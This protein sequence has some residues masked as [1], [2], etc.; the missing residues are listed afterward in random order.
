MASLQH[1]IE[2]AVSAEQ[3]W[4]ALRE[5]GQTAR[6]F[7]P[8]LVE[9]HVDRDIRTVRFADGTVVEERIV[10]IDDE[11]RRIAY[12]VVK[13]TPMTHHNASMQIIDAGPGRCRFVWI[14]DFLPNDFGASMA[15]LVEQGSQA[16]KQN[17]E[18]RAP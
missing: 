2:I 10:D 11:R 7:K 16:L 18:R 13:G 12:S 14:T 6:L 4:A 17:L 8:V 3:A 1:E 9:G 15:P 5:L